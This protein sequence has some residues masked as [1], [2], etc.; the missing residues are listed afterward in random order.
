MSHKKRQSGFTIVEILISVA[1][2]AALLAAVAAAMQASFQN[3]SE[4]QKTTVLTQTARVV[5]GRMMR[6]VRTAEAID[7]TDTSLTITPPASGSGLE[8]IQ[9]ELSGETLYYRQTINSMTNTYVLLG[10]SSD[11]QV[12]S[13]S[14]LR[15][16]DEDEH[17]LS[18]TVRLAFSV[19]GEEL[20]VTATSAVRRNQTY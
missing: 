15:E 12:T 18:V 6:E 20:A 8:E 4:N 5:L 17:T 13:F 7:S 3:Y 10:G 9:Y 11:V 14:I 1:L 16:I 2:L 19:D